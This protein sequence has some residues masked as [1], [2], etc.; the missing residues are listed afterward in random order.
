MLQN[1]GKELRVKV[2]SAFAKA[3]K[4]MFIPSGAVTQVDDYLAIATPEGYL[5]I[6]EMQLEGKKKM[7]VKDLLNGYKFAKNAKMR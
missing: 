7:S 1:D 5:C 6:T 2:Y 4:E 3:E